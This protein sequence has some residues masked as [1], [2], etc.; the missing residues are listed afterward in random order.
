[1][2]D[3]DASS[4][5]FVPNYHHRL[6]W[7]SPGVD[8]VNTVNRDFF[9]PESLEAPDKRRVMWAW[10]RDKSIQSLSIQS[11]P[12]ELSPLNDTQLAFN[13]LKEL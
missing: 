13:P 1:M 10:L 11:L 3:W 5:Q 12:C 7:P 9:A 8:L 6:N 2:G 4:E